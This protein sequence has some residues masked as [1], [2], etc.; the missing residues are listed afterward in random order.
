MVEAEIKLVDAIEE[1]PASGEVAKPKD[2][3]KQ[4]VA[5]TAGNGA[6]A[7]YSEIGVS[8]HRVAEWR[9]LMTPACR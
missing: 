7:T 9:R 3:L 2:I 1:G 6:P 5:R 8:R 4:S